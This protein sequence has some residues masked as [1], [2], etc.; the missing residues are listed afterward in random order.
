MALGDDDW[1]AIPLPV[2]QSVRGTSREARQF[3][4]DV[5]T[6]A[7]K[8]LKSHRSRIF[9]TDLDPRQLWTAYLNGLPTE[10]RQEYTCNTCRSFV[11]CAGHLALIDDS[12]ALVP[13]FWSAKVPATFKKTC[14]EIAARF[15]DA[16]VV[17]EYKPDNGAKQDIGKAQTVGFHHLHF[18]VP[19]DRCVNPQPRGVTTL[20]TQDAA[21]MLARVLSDYSLESVEKAHQILSQHKLPGADNHIGATTWLLDIVS[22]SRIP[23]KEE[24]ARHNLLYRYA[25]T[26]FPGC[27][28]QL[29][30]GPLAKL[31]GHLESSTG[32]DEIKREWTAL[33]DPDKYMRPTVAPRLGN[34]QASEKLFNDLGL[35][36]ADMR[37]RFLCAD[38]VPD[39][40]YLWQRK[41]PKTELK[42]FGSVATS[43]AKP[44][45]DLPPS[46]ISFTKLVTQILP[47][48]SR[49]WLKIPS[50]KAI[51]FFITGYEDTKPLMQWHNDSNRVSTYVYTN[52]SHVAKHGLRAEDWNEAY[53]LIPAPWLWDVSEAVKSFP[54][55]SDADLK[56]NEDGALEGD[57]AQKPGL[58]YFHTKNGIKYAFLLDGV[59]DKS[60]S[61]L[62]LFPQWLRGDLHGVRS[63]IEQYSNQGTKYVPVD[64]TERG[65]YVGAV[66]YGRGSDKNVLVR[67]EGG[68]MPGVWEI[69]CF[70]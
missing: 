38:E 16:R 69:S 23:K 7:S 13:L 67:T 28:S 12:G 31:L 11:K 62:C 68:R 19:P 51:N 46:S 65:G 55:P 32:F 29:R 10:K 34:V 2:R 53:G 44:T 35:T 14:T 4:N 57:G 25:A 8:L 66:S 45:D 60:S 61:S 48:A 6:R 20:S 58:Q 54:L 21:T 22:R 43:T 40:T 52:P 5:E 47:T 41:K 36:A 42:I 27:L 9:T 56:A 3:L 33:T 18:Y 24:A 49:V 50:F 63:T 39:H 30:S 64:I 70:E 26:A 59:Y 15:S 17:A 37:R 1:E